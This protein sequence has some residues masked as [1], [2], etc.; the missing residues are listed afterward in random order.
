MKP[1]RDKAKAMWE[2]PPEQ[3]SGK[4][5]CGGCSRTTPG[6]LAP[7]GEGVRNNPAAA[8]RGGT[9]A[10]EED[11]QRKAEVERQQV[12]R[13]LGSVLLAATAAAAELETAGV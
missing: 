11:R 2:Q 6:A 7:R 10:E 12:A 4:P 13:K 5:R 3:G 8:S 9:G 1:K